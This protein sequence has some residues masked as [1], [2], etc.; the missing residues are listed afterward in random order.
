MVLQFLE[1][2]YRLFEEQKQKLFLDSE[3]NSH[4][5]EGKNYCP[6]ILPFRSRQDIFRSDV[7]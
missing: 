3:N 5:R 6:Y 2:A 1:P 4:W 7:H